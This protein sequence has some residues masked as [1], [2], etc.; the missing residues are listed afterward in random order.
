[1]GSHASSGRAS[2]TG[3]DTVDLETE[4]QS[5]NVVMYRSGVGLFIVGRRIRICHMSDIC[6]DS[7]ACDGVS[8][9]DGHV[10][11]WEML[12]SGVPERQMCLRMHQP[13]E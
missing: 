7:S 1:M 3:A 11:E 2:K 5:S 9:V 12:A 13:A 4:Q 10:G 6:K 8:E